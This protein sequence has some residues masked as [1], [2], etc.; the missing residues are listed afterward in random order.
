[1]NAVKIL[2]SDPELQA[3]RTSCEASSS[4]EIKKSSSFEVSKVICRSLISF[5]HFL[6]PQSSDS[7]MKKR[8]DLNFSQILD[9][10]KTKKRSLSL[11]LVIYFLSI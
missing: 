1:M 11:K 3:L 9:L 10:E 8:E 7:E 5:E 4:R 2:S 6:K